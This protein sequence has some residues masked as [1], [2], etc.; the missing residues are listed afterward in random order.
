[1]SS[2]SKTT[3]SLLHGCYVCMQE[4]ALAVTG[5]TGAQVAAQWVLNRPE[6]ST[7]WSIVKQGSSGSVLCSRQPPAVCNQSALQVGLCHASISCTAEFIALV[8]CLLCLLAPGV[9]LHFT[10][11]CCLPLRLAKPHLRQM[12]N[13]RR[14]IQIERNASQAE[15][16]RHLPSCAL[17]CLSVQRHDCRSSCRCQLVILLAVEIALQQQL[18]WGI[19]GDMTFLPPWLWQMQ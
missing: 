15:R 5:Q 3:S 1:M 2:A 6:S 17:P 8:R 14:Q 13:E 4:E 9:L 10:V 16:V 19:S 11:A 7:Q 18:S 12:Q